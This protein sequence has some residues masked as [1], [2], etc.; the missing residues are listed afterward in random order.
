MELADGRWLLEVTGET[1]IE[2]EHWLPDDP[3]PA[4]LVARSPSR[5]RA[6]RTPTRCSR[7]PGSGCGRPGRCWRSTE[8]R[9]RSRPTLAL[10]GDGDT[11]VASWQLCAA[12]PV[13]AYDA[14]Q[15]LAADGAAERLR[16]LVELMEDLELDLQ[17]MSASD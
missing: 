16:L 9:R 8:A 3:Y 10:D 2:V 15:L 14:Q 17:R 13:N 5:C 11:E 4:A 7:R 12:A 6:W 1:L